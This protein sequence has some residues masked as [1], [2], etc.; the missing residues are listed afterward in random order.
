M[1][2]IYTSS[3]ASS[4]DILG[5]LVYSVLALTALVIL[6]AWA[7]QPQYDPE[8]YDG[9]AGDENPEPP[10]P[11]TP[12]HGPQ[13]EIE[14]DEVQGVPYIATLPLWAAD[15]QVRTRA[16]VIQLRQ[17][18]LANMSGYELRRVA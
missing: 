10:E 2:A 12:S 4:T 1:E 9:D 8:H 5:I 7:E 6:H 3:E 14:P 11:T 18:T 16:Q 13:V 15:K 17:R